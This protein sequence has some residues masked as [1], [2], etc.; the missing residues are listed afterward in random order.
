[1]SIILDGTAGITSPGWNFTTTL[2]ATNQVIS[3][4]LTLSSATANGVL[5]ANA[6]NLVSSGSAL[7]FDGSNLSSSGNITSGGTLQALTTVQSSSGA[8]LSLNANGANRDV[9]LKVNGT[10][11]AR[12]VGSTGNLG[13]GTTAPATKL[14]VSGS[15]PSMRV[16]GTAGT[17][18][19]LELSSGG[20]VNWSL[21]SNN[22][23]GSDFTIFQDSTERVRIDSS[24]NVGIGTTNPARPLHVVGSTVLR[25]ETT[26]ATNGTAA[27]IYASAITAGNFQRFA[28]RANAATTV[29]SGID[30]YFQNL[31]AGSETAD[32]AFSTINGV[33]GLTEKVRITSAGSV[34]I[35]TTAP[36][37]IFEVIGVPYFTR[38][39]KSALINPNYSAANVKTQLQAPAGMALAL[40]TNGDNDRVTI[41]VS[42]NVGIGTTAPVTPLD[43]RGST[44]ATVRIGSLTHGGAGDEFANIEF[45]W[46]DPDAA[47]VKTKIYAKNVG[48]VGPGGGGAAD[49]LFAT[50]PAAG[51]LTE[52]FRL[53]NT[54]NIGVNS[55][56]PGEKLEV[57]GNIH[58][59]GS[60]GAVGTGL[61]YF[62]GAASDN[63][64]LSITRVGTA[65]MAF[66]RYNPSWLESMRIDGSG[67]VGIGT[68]STPTR[69]TITDGATPYAAATGSMVQIKRNVSNG[70]D[71]SRTGL[72]LANNSNGFQIYYGGTSDRLRFLDG[73]DIEILTLVNGGNVGIGTT[74][75][76]SKLQI[77]DSSSPNV[78]LHYSGAAAAG[79]KGILYFTHNRNS[80]SAQEL[81]GYIQGV[82]EDNQSAGGI[83]FVARN[84]T[85][86]ETFRITSA[87]RFG[88]STT[89]P[90][91]LL[92]VYPG[93]GSA[94]VLRTTSDTAGA[95]AANYIESRI[96]NFS[97]VSGTN[98]VISNA[99]V[100]ASGWRVIL[101]GTWSNNY[102]GGGLSYYAPFIELNSA[103]PS[104][105]IGSRTFT[106]SRNGSGYLIA[107]S[108][109]AY[110]LSFAGYIEIYDNP[111]SLQPTHS[112]RLLG[113]VGI[114]TLAPSARL[115]VAS[116][117]N[118]NP[119]AIF[120]NSNSNNGIIQLGASGTAYQILG[121]DYQGNLNLNIAGSYPILLSTNSTERVRITGTGNVG[122]G[123]TNPQYKL[124]VGNGK[125]AYQQGVDWQINGY[126]QATIPV[127][128][129]ITYN[130]WYRIAQSSASGAGGAGQRGSFEIH[131]GFT[132]NY[133]S[134]SH[135]I[136]RGFKDWGTNGGISSVECQ[137]SSPF[138][139][140]R[141]AYD[142]TY[143]YLEGYMNF[144]LGGGSGAAGLAVEVYNLDAWPENWTAYTTLTAS[145]GITGTIGYT[146]YP[147]IGG[148]ALTQPLFVSGNPASYIYSINCINTDM[149]TNSSSF[150][151]TSNNADGGGTTWA[152]I[153]DSYINFSSTSGGHSGNWM[154]PV[155]LDAGFYRFRGSVRLS[156]TNGAIHGNTSASNYKYTASFRFWISSGP[157]TGSLK[158]DVDTLGNGTRA[159][160]SGGATYMTA[161]NYQIQY[162]TN[163]YEGIK[164]VYITDLYLDRVG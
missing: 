160:F 106:I 1:M 26:S 92:D 121:G 16:S 88:I 59:F 99:A 51:L 2:T 130:G 81:L 114:G 74:A 154:Y 4:S 78:R 147:T 33:A 116:S 140:Y 137:S 30:T 97:V 118:T 3:S 43:V 104:T 29:F 8:D 144:T 57:G 44:T 39:G 93:V 149:T 133:G 87:G 86:V 124:Y 89:A 66:G 46:A 53:T 38:G 156:S 80:D 100:S 5:Y 47:E 79:N 85:D 163:G 164:Q 61:A 134:P 162:A 21:R 117:D 77:T 18:P 112:M 102:E 9:I 41:D 48:N 139:Q 75:P 76:A 11:L 54:G 132:G 123:S 69:L 6:S 96:T 157:D 119:S 68:T 111:Q 34:G 83:R 113:H 84:N 105:T 71:S 14:E 148:L 129:G 82:A 131:L 150:D 17:V 126:H 25:V 22:G 13:V 64:D 24:G 91:S 19:K 90:Q 143:A 109:D 127:T 36:Q 108:N 27:E 152:I 49:L 73:G 146:A 45:Y 67:N 155:Y 62:M 98:Q 65:A 115:H 153:K 37:G 120:Q 136:I 23:G 161:G 145:S 159:G 70:L 32:I 138:T 135:T 58:V 125:I 55:T 122:I 15:G 63:R 103:A 31:T 142:S 56:T 7:S 42:G 101:R 20:V 52:R 40:A 10:E 141:I 35:G 94:A 158:W 128:G 95:I 12:L 28:W 50:R 60:A 110:R 151:Y 107:N 72:V